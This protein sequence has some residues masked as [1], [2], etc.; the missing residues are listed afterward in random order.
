[1]AT[2]PAICQ[3]PLLAIDRV[4]PFVGGVATDE[5]GS[6]P[7][8]GDIPWCLRRTPRTVKRTG[9]FQ[10]CEDLAR[11]LPQ[12][13]HRPQ[14]GGR[15]LPV[16]MILAARQR[17][18]IAGCHRYVQPDRFALSRRANTEARFSR[19]S[20]DDLPKAR[21]RL[22]LGVR[23]VTE[24]DAPHAV[25]R[26]DAQP[27]L[28]QQGP[29]IQDH[30]DPFVLTVLSQVSRFQT[31]WRK[32]VWASPKQMTIQMLVGRQQ[33]LQWPVVADCASYDQHDFGGPRALEFFHASKQPSWDRLSICDEQQT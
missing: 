18:T 17:T 3:H 25:A 23:A 22:C 2:F 24:A 1:M 26:K 7:Q 8:H 27:F 20:F 19:S 32:S 10:P 21:R 30:V 12:S 29:R 5:C 4:A 6:S 16:D 11:I 14:Q 33:E 15:D 31:D 28:W 9:D 13:Q